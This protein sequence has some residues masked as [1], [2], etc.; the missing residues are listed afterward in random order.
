VPTPIEQI[1]LERMDE[2]IEQ[3]G[4]VAERQVALLARMK[5]DRDAYARRIG[6]PTRHDDEESVPCP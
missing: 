3:Q 4:R 1:A 5:A 2:H 6:A